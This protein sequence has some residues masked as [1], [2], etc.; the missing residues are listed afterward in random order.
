MLYATINYHFIISEPCA[1]ADSKVKSIKL[2]VR[3]SQVVE[4]IIDSD[5]RAICLKS[6]TDQQFQVEEENEFKLFGKI[7]KF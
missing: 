3:Q 2:K 1:I 7:Y 4:S 6:K 5:E